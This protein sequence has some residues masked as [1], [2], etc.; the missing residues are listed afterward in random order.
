MLGQHRR[1]NP[2]GI[3]RSLLARLAS[4]RSPCRSGVSLPL[5]HECAFFVLVLH[6]HASLGTRACGVLHS[7]ADFEYIHFQ[8][9]ATFDRTLIRERGT[10]LGAEARGKGVNV[11]LAPGVS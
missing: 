8:A 9:A 5:W 10:Q 11:L 4:R 7:C 2:H 6:R 1:G 3:S